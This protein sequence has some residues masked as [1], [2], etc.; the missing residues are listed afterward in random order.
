MKEK[1]KEIFIKYNINTTDEIIDNFSIFFKELIEWNQ[2]FNL[3]NI[4]NED[5][6]IIKHFIDSVLPHNFIP[7][8]SKILD[9]GAG[10]GFP[11]LPL[12]LIRDDLNIIMLDSL[13]K[14]V[15][16]LN[17]IIEN[18]KLT[19]ITAIHSR[20][21]DFNQRNQFDVVVARAVASLPTL[22]EYSL[23]FLKV[24]GIL[25]AYKSNNAKIEID[26]SKNALNLVGGE[27]NEVKYYNIENNNRCIIV[28]KKIKPTK[29]IYPRKKNL[30]KTNPL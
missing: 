30:P 20:V 18:L 3:T 28:I 25:L 22:I 27:L 17:H 4:T 1:L 9:I 5:E 21:E 14:R 29:T 6:V 10:A 7:Q 2:K 8:F 13:N 16:F 15:V 19:K 26:A 11:S 23:P 12:K 24:G